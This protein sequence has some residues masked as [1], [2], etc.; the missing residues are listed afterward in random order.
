M[1]MEIRRM[2]YMKMAEERYRLLWQII[3]ERK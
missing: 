3:E 2:P 1:D